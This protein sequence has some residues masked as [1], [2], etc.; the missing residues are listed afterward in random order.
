[1]SVRSA[2]PFVNPLAPTSKT[3][4]AKKHGIGG[5]YLGA[6]R[7]AAILANSCFKK[8]LACIFMHT[9]DSQ[10][11]M[12]RVIGYNP[13]GLILSLLGYGQAFM[14]LS[15]I[16]LRGINRPLMRMQWTSEVGRGPY[17]NCV[18]VHVCVCVCVFKSVCAGL[19]W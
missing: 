13:G 17:C 10:T 4:K 18:A 3:A 12:A 19:A 6:F 14:P 15:C 1:M 9:Q 2:L 8:G 7:I 5:Q 16:A 11:F